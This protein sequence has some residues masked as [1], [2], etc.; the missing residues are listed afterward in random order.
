MWL[1]LEYV[2]GG[3]LGQKV[4][5]WRELNGGRVPLRAAADMMSRVARTVDFA[6]QRDVLHRD[7]KPSNILLTPEAEPKIADFG[8]A[9]IQEEYDSG[10]TA[11]IHGTVIGTPA[12]MAPEQWKGKAASRATDIYALGTILYEMLAG[13]RPFAHMPNHY[14]LMYHAVNEQPD[15]LTQLRP[16]MAPELNAICLKCLEKAPENR[17][18]T[19]AALAEAL[20]HWLGSGREDG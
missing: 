11:T 17:Y 15:A 3:D 16:D 1:I 4:R 2:G 6:H 12:Y 5:Q 7:L 10:V 14:A 20:E 9:K 13:E 19:A 18:P 8:L